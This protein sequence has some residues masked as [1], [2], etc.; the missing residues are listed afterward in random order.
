MM[1][2][3]YLLPCI[4]LIMISVQVCTDSGFAAGTASGT[5]RNDD[6]ASLQK[7]LVQDGF[8]AEQVKKLYGNA[9]VY[10]DTK[11]VSLYFVHR[12]SKLNY[13]QF[14]DAEPIRKAKV[15]M[16][17]NRNA[18]NRAGQVYGVSPR[19]ITAILLVE[20]RLGTYVGN[21]LVFNTLSTMSALSDL[22]VRKRLW[23][24]V[25]AETRLSKKEFEEKARKKS[26]WA[27][28]ELRAFLRYTAKENLNPL[29]IIGSYAGAMG[30]CQF[31]PSNIPLY[32]RDGNGDGRIDLFTH[33]DA[34]LSI[35][36]YLH[37]Y[38]WRTGISREKAFRVVYKYNHS[39]YYVNT[40]LKIADRLGG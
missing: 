17:E 40:V 12:E 29:E 19:V 1:K 6:F 16:A 18:L 11:G 28:Q 8:H 25:A 14:L 23:Q 31:M 24:E 4:F 30:Y 2:K 32:A 15:Y 22:N 34:I 13:D 5:S 26:G 7:Q 9:A 33:A 27:Y 39:K 10:F 38:G 21:R 35:A 37:H 36:S 3:K 20:T